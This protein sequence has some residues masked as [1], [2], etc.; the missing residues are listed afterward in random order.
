MIRARELWSGIVSVSTQSPGSLS[1]DFLSR[2]VNLTRGADRCETLRFGV[3]SARTRNVERNRAKLLVQV[4]WGLNH[5]GQCGIK[6]SF[7]CSISL[8]NLIEP[9]WIQLTNWIPGRKRQ[10]SDAQPKL[11]SRYRAP[12]LFIYAL[13][14]AV[15][16]FPRPRSFF[17]FLTR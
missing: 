13:F 6:T 10:C 12:F 9:D 17:S 8:L 15:F 11:S 5:R 2:K 1:L 16:R 3:N 14:F 7:W 4:S